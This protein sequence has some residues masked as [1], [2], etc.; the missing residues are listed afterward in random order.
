MRID[1][2]LKA[3][4]TGMNG[5]VAPILAKVLLEDGHKVKSWDRSLVPIDNVNSVKEFI[6]K[7]KPDWFFHIATG[8]ADWAELLAQVCFEQSIKFLFTSSVSVFSASQQGPFTR[9][10][11]PKP[12]DDYGRYKL[13]CEQRVRQVNSNALIVRLGWQIGTSE[14]GNQMVEFLNNTFQNE[15]NIE[16]S[17]NWYPACSFLEDTASSLVDIMQNKLAGL[18]QLDGNPGLNFYKIVVGINRLLNKSWE[19][20]AVDTPIQNNLMLDDRIQIN[21]ILETI[22]N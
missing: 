2:I 4:I 19:I 18:Y 1:S 20:I 7:E 9:N 13:V 8:S 11:Q 22:N 6:I 12:V 16:A 17:T 15:G 14:S 3:I 5:T 10:V 21:S